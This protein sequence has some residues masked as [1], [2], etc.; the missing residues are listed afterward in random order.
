MICQADQP[1]GDRPLQ[2]VTTSPR[3][4]ASDR[5]FM[6]AATPTM[7]LNQP[8]ESS[9]WVLWTFSITTSCVVVAMTNI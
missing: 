2:G 3:E 5:R 6:R 1:A 9:L 7:A 4:R 8:D